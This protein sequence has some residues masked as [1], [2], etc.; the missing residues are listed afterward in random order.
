MAPYDNYLDTGIYDFHKVSNPN[1]PRLTE[2]AQEGSSVAVPEQK[3]D[4]LGFI[5]VTEHVSRKGDNPV[6]F[7]TPTSTSK[8]PEV[9]KYSEYPLV[10]RRKFNVDEKPEVHISSTLEINDSVLK[11]TAAHALRHHP[12]IDLSS[13][14]I[15]IPYPFSELFW[16]RN[17]LYEYADDPARGPL[18]Q[19]KIKLLK[20]FIQERIHKTLSRWNV[21]VPQNRIISSILWTIYR[22]NTIIMSKSD[23]TKR[24]Y[25]IRHAWK[26]DEGTKISCYYWSY[27]DGFFGKVLEELLI[28]PFEGVRKITDLDYVPWEY[29]PYAEQVATKQSLIARGHRWRSLLSYNHVSYNGLMTQLTPKKRSDGRAFVPPKFLEVHV[30]I[31]SRI[32]TDQKTF[33]RYSPQII[34]QLDNTSISNASLM[35]SST[36]TDDSSGTGSCVDVFVNVPDNTQFK[37]SDQQAL[38][39]P[40][41]VAGY[42]LQEKLWGHFLVDR[43]QAIKFDRE[44][45][46]Q[47]Q[48]DHEVKRIM[49]SLVTVHETARKR[50]KDIIFRKG[51]GRVFLLHGPPGSGKTLTAETLSEYAEK[52]LYC[53]TTGQLGTEVRKVEDELIKVFTLSQTWGAVILI[54]EADVFLARRTVENIDRNAYVSIFLRFLEYYQGIMILTTNRRQDFDE[55]FAS[56]I[57]LSLDYKSPNDD[58]RKAIWRGLFA[59]HYP[60]EQMDTDMIE[61]LGANYKLN[62][63]EIKNL[64]S[65]AHAISIAEERKVTLDDLSIIHNMSQASKSQDSSS[66]KED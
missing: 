22:P 61:T 44:C 49:R 51:L 34:R 46:N 56:R 40:P 20:D 48:I 24:C 36:T 32:I 57:H 33:S 42:A 27:K 52:P 60:K 31:N 41:T 9:A 7:K 17:E 19:E 10:L 63:R 14:S 6:V 15:D 11:A 62:G 5:D 12:F 50:Q 1:V 47:L 8:E 16:Y 37:L 59:R 38:L 28:E 23:D 4:H 21:H 39:C 30:F 13:P 35:N 54:D 26:T 29:I 58:Q 43:I 53:V 25:R 55:A 64:F 18:E 2:E 66:D 3:H 65:T 45:F